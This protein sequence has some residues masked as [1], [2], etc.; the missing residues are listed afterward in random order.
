MRAITYDRYGAS[1]V[2]RIVEIAEPVPR[3]GELKVRVRAASL[4][5]VDVKIRAGHTRLVP[6]FERPPRGTGVDFAGEVVGTGGGEVAGYF[7]G[8]R[9]FG[10]LSPF[11]RA[12][13][14]AEY[15]CVTPDRIALTPSSLGDGEAAALPI[16]GGTAVQALDD[17]AHLVHGQ[18]VL[19]NGATGGVGHFAVQYARHVGAHVTAVCGP[20]NVAFARDLGADAVLD[21]THE[22]FTAGTAIFDVIFDATGHVR[23][24]RCR[25]VLAPG[26]VYINTSPD[27]ASVLA[28]I[29]EAAAARLTGRQRVVGLVLKGGAEAW[30]R[31]ARLAESGALRPHIRATIGLGD[32]AEAGR[33][34]E[35]GHG[36]GKVVVD[37]SR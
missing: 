5:P 3:S 15:V 6:M 37:P 9:V 22:D 31:L 7:P 25:N 13:S 19:V 10:S 8:A 27:A 12:G 32:V 16:A 18:R 34:M 28:T 17:H 21:Y 35:T 11:G 20:A 2:L 36:R 14:F 29:A 4:N 24:R 30:R 33:Q 1:D 23:W 26:G